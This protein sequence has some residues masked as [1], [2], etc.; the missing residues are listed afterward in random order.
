MV[1]PSRRDVDAVRSQPHQDDEGYAGA[2][3][4]RLRI[5]RDQQGLSLMAVE[6]TSDGEFKASALGSCER[7]ERVIS[8][9]RLQRLAAHYH[10]SVE[11][12]FP[13]PPSALPARSAVTLLASR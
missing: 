6:A 4:A 12:L 1:E 7:G 3:G 11:S 9:A 8:V 10:I 2:V 5:V 13:D